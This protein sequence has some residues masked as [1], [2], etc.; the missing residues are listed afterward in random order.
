MKASSPS[1][2]EIEFTTPL[3]CRHFSPA[4]ITLHFELSIITGTGA[5]SGSAAMRFR[6]RTMAASESSIPS[7]MLTSMTWAPL[8]TCWR[9]TATA[10][11]KSPPRISFENRGEPVTLVRSPMFTKFVSGRSVSASQPDRRVKGSTRGAT[12]GV[13]PRTAS[14]MARMC[15]GVVPQQPPTRLSQPFRAHS[16]STGAMS[17]GVSGNPVGNSGLGSPALG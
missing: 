15:S 2:S 3:P 6:K 16:P 12:R 14:A 5:M 8:V 11:S 13:A 9:A 7:S 10:S 4:S 1:F 17:A